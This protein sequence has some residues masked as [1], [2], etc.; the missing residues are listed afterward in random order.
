MTDRELVAAVA[1]HVMGWQVFREK[2]RWM[3]GIGSPEMAIWRESEVMDWDPLNEIAD[4]YVMESSIPESLQG[5]YGGALVGIVERENHGN[6]TAWLLAH[7]TPRQR[8]LAALAAKGVEV[9]E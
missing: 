6:A 3:V 1:E 9:T 4:A 8:C 2:R 7:A 5:Q